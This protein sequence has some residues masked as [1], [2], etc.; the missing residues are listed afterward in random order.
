MTQEKDNYAFISDKRR[1]IPVANCRS[2]SNKVLKVLLRA[3]FGVPLALLSYG[4]FSIGQMC[5]ESSF[6]LPR[7][8]NVGAKKPTLKWIRSAFEKDGSKV[9]QRHT[10]VTTN[11]R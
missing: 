1:Y 10:L 3:S 2:C 7:R 5:N 8:E 6:T 11:N 4:M 9:M